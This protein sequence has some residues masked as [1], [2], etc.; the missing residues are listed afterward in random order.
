MNTGVNITIGTINHI[1][2]KRYFIHSAE[3]LVV[4][5]SK[6]VQQ[7]ERRTKRKIGCRKILNLPFPYRYKIIGESPVSTIASP[8]SG[9][10]KEDPPMNMVIEKGRVKKNK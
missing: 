2:A 6:T 5:I 1:L 4:N 7:I 8:S 3:L 10:S 9:S